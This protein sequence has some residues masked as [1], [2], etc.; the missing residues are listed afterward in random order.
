MARTANIGLHDNGAMN[1]CTDHAE[2]Q[3][4]KGRSA[5]RATSATARRGYLTNGANEKKN[6][7]AAPMKA[8]MSPMRRRWDTDTGRPA[9]VAGC[10]WEV[11]AAGWWM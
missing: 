7:S 3:P 6:T 11:A 10:H 9:D 4:S 1:I 5:A 2:Y 8:N